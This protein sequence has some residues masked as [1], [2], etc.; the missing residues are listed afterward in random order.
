MMQAFESSEIHFGK[1]E[2]KPTP[3]IVRRA[4]QDFIVCQEYIAAVR[5]PVPGKCHGRCVRQ[6]HASG[7]FP[8]SDTHRVGA[9]VGRTQN[10]AMAVC[11]SRLE[12][13]DVRNSGQRHVFKRSIYSNAL[14][15]LTGDQGMVGPSGTFAPGIGQDQRAIPDRSQEHR[16]LKSR[17]TQQW[18]GNAL[19]DAERVEV[20]GNSDAQRQTTCREIPRGLCRRLEDDRSVSSRTPDTSPTA[21]GVVRSPHDTLRALP[22][23]PRRRSCAR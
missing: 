11:Q 12:E 3:L 23:R 2:M 1:K 19:Q 17:K 9:Q 8:T 22:V 20:H 18:Q 14:C 15:V 16:P 13:D 10:R 4:A 21:S 6:P 7:E 5:Y